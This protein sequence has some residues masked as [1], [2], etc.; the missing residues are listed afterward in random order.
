MDIGELSSDEEDDSEFFALGHE[1]TTAR[2]SLSLL[3]CFILLF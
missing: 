1:V 3:F 2:P